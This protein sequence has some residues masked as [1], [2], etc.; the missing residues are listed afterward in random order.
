MQYRKDIQI[1]RGIAVVLVVLY[2]LSIGGFQSGFLGVDVFFVIS[3]FLMAVLYDPNRTLEFFQKRSLRLLPAYF[4]TIIVTI[5][6]SVFIVT[7]GEYRQVLAQSTYADFFASNI[8][9][10]IQSPYFSRS[11]FNP[12]LHLW[13]L[14]VEIQFYLLIP[15]IFLFLGISRWF[16]W[17]FLLTSLGLCFAVVEVSPKTS[18]YMMPMRLWEF[19]IGYG[20]AKYLTDKGSVRSRAYSWLGSVS[21]FAILAIP[22]LSVRNTASFI[23][24]HPGLY[25]LGIALAT[26][27]IIAVGLHRVL[28]NSVFGDYLELLGKYSYSIYL[29][30]FP[31][32]VLS[33]YK[34]FS[35]T[36]MEIDGL[37]RLIS[38]VALTSLLSYASFQLV[39]TRLRNAPHIG[40]ILFLAPFL[41]LAAANI[42]SAVNKQP[43]SARELLVFDAFSDRDTYRCGKMFRVLN[44]FEIACEITKHSA[45][46]NQNILFVG[47]SHADSIKQS[48]ATTANKSN[49]G[50]YFLV[51]NNPL[52]SGSTVNAARLVEEALVKNANGIVLHYALDSISIAAVLELVKMARA[53]DILVSFIMPVPT[54][55]KHVPTALW[56]SMVAS[57]EL[58][59][60]TLSDYQEKT[61]ELQSYLAG[62][63]ADNFV[64]YDVAQYFCSET[65]S[66]VEVSGQPL[67]FDR[68]HLTLTGSFRLTPVFEEI[69][70]DG[71]RFAARNGQIK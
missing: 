4:V 65:C 50:V 36:I 8:G 53:H 12:L 61:G 15:A 45:N 13:S 56:E 16:F 42:G 1:L 67:Y 18:F 68:G 6:V 20:V 27:V 28:E 44:P 37:F 39:E 3:G 38:V 55:D 35:G 58:P 60:R 41:V 46:R 7:P 11:E 48:L 52:T 40:R 29:V 63:D 30:H 23:E 21:L 66:R 47:D 62:I 57:T 51:R 5:V 24:G 14:G 19:L 70:T 33:M 26:G 54:W 17:L 22:A 2:H 32:I 31:V 34:P 25:A 71:L 10:W 59:S 9:F 49:V 69:V 64:V 43:Y